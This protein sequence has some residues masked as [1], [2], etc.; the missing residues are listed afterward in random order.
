MH[1]SNIHYWIATGTNATI[2]YRYCPWVCIHMYV[3]YTVILHNINTP[4]MTL[5]TSSWQK[6]RLWSILYNIRSQKLTAW[7]RKRAGMRKTKAIQLHSKTQM[8]KL[9]TA[10]RRWS[11]GSVSTTAGREADGWFTTT[12]FCNVSIILSQC[13]RHV[14]CSNSKTLSA[15]SRTTQANNGTLLWYTMFLHI[16]MSC[17]FPYT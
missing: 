8:T 13:L 3:L 10:K 7:E 11:L 4:C 2:I 14:Y 16:I 12:T 15:C 9:M 5:C 17:T 1:K 6:V